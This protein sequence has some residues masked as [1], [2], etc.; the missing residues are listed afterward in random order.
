MAA[1]L[2]SGRASLCAPRA[3]PGAPLSAAHALCPQPLRAA[4]PRR[5]AALA[6]HAPRRRA[7]RGL[8]LRASAAVNVTVVPGVPISAAASAKVDALLV[9]IANTD[10]GASA[11]P[12]ARRRIQ[13]LATELE[14]DFAATGVRCGACVALRRCACM[15]AAVTEPREPHKNNGA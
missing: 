1:S 4:P 13:S 6:T 14:A 3:A 15:R 8:A 9:E 12:E 7:A 10:A 5:A 2:C 11:T